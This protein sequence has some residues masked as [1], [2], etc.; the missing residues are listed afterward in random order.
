MRCVHSISFVWFAELMLYFLWIYMNAMKSF[1]PNVFL[2]GPCGN[3]TRSNASFLNRLQEVVSWFPMD[4][5]LNCFHILSWKYYYVST[6]CWS[7][8]SSF[9]FW[10]Q[11]GPEWDFIVKTFLWHYFISHLSCH[12]QYMLP[13][14][15]P[16]SHWHRID[17]EEHFFKSRGKSQIFPEIYYCLLNNGVITRCR[18][19]V[20]NA[21]N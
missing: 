3:W 4:F 19:H 13:N 20:A 12:Q 11:D 16:Q 15:H 6:W 21:L 2:Y 17:E 18:F 10:T 5:M 14:N 9:L 1:I 8:F 7:H